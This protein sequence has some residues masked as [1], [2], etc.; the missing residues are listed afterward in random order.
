MK[1]KGF[2]HD[3]GQVP[4]SSTCLQFC[5]Y[6]CLG[7]E[8]FFHV[9]NEIEWILFL[10]FFSFAI[11]YISQVS[12]A[13]SFRVASIYANIGKL[14]QA[15]NGETRKSWKFQ[16]YCRFLTVVKYALLGL[17]SSPQEDSAWCK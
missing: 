2:H 8:F 16:C 14:V 13:I 11:V 3:A 5:L 7:V 15:G 6:S 1:K 12:Q 4:H 17:C 10:S 9:I